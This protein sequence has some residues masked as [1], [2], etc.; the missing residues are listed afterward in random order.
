MHIR[1]RI[2]ELRR[3]PAADLLPNP[4]NWRTHPPRQREALQ[5]VLA[6]IG[7][8]LALLARE[9]AD[10]QL[11]L[12][13]GHLRAETT[14]NVSVPVLVL[15]VS[16]EEADKL[17]ATLDPLSSLAGADSEKLSALLEGVRTG[18]PVLQELLGDLAKSALPQSTAADTEELQHQYNIIVTCDDERQ[19]S[20]L[21]QRF[22][23]EGL[24]CRAL[25]V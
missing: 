6:E 25:V 13:D 1:D 18:N 22:T 19:Q 10:G 17:L 20:D 14:P 24:T 4:R 5:A 2:R 21:L 12:I 23:D 9:T 11:M 3:I 15:D 16:E 7:Y 8:A